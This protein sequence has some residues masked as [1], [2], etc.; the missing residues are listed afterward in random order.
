MASSSSRAA[1]RIHAL[2]PRGQE[3][4]GRGRLRGRSGPW[5][6]IRAAPSERSMSTST[7]S[8]RSTSPSIV[9][10]SGVRATPAPSAGRSDAAARASALVRTSSS[11]ELRGAT[12]STSPQ[13]RAWRPFDPLGPRGEDVGEVPPDV[14]LVDHPG[15][16]AGARE[17]G[18]Q[19]QLGERHRRRPIV[20]QQDLVAGQRQL[21][22]AAGGGAVD[23]G[24][25]DLAGVG[26]GVLDGVAGLV[27][28]LAEVHLVAV[29]RA[30][31]H[32]DVGAGAEHLVEAA[33]E[34]PRRAPRDARSAAAARRRRARC[35]RPGRRSSAS[36]R[37]RRG[38][39]RPGRRP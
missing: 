22:A 33:G 11:N 10:R 19:R 31:Q 9:R 27:G 38:G 1:A 20:D 5:T 35:R 21:V 34:R 7:W 8:Y 3:L 18:Q 4:V 13:S 26:G 15:Q 16:A 25:P 2:G 37:S 12:A 6:V 32:L 23:R 24:D 14:A 28:E 17:H 29:R 36:A 30:R 39:R